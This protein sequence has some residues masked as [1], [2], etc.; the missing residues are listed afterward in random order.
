MGHLLSDFIVGLMVTS[1]KRAYATHYMSKVC[2]NQRACPCGRPLMIRASTGDNQTLK[3]RRGSISVGSLGPGGCKVLF[4]PLKHL[5]PVW[6]LT[7]NMVS[8]L[9]P[10]CWGFSFALGS[11]VAFF[12]GIEHSL[13]DDLCSSPRQTTQYYNNPNLYPIH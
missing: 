2:C 9:L 6:G 7:L 12:G 10:S 8:P 3:G 5:W 1:S 11:G 4:E 13:V